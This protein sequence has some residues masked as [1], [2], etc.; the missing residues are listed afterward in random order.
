M[1]N[2]YDPDFIGDGITIPM[3]T[4][5]RSLAQ[6]VL[7][8]AG[9]LRD[10][11]YSDHLHFSLVMNEHTRQ[12][13]YSAYNIDQNQYRSKVKGKGKRGWRNAPDIG[14]ENQLDN[15]YYKDRKNASGDTIPN[16]Y[17]RGHM[18]MRS[19]NMWGATRSEE[20]RVGKEGRL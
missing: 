11:I 8:K 4:F 9:S 17:D 19:N 7:R 3:P 10:D 18:V 14:A 2:G 1:Q 20:R 16:P 13:I 12:L 15:D 6:S 5:S